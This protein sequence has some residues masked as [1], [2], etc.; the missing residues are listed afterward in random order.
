MTIPPPLTFAALHRRELT[1]DP[2]SWIVAGL[3]PLAAL[4]WR[5][6]APEVGVMS[7]YGVAALLLPPAVVS[8]VGARLARRTTWAFW[9]S[10]ATRPAGAYRG[11]VVGA[12][13]GV[14][15]PQAAGA[16]VSAAILGAPLDAAVGLVVAVAII[17]VT[18]AVVAGVAAAATLDP[19]KAV[20]IGAAIWGIGVIAFEPAL[21]ALAGAFANRPYEP[22][23]ATLVLMHPLELA[24]VALLQTID[25]PVFVGPTGLLVGRWLGGAAAAWAGASAIVIAV[26][27]TVVA[28]GVFARRE[29]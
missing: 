1:R 14:M 26:A 5:T 4:T 29:R 24:R 13:A 22:W 7:V 8:L 6:L 3:L 11:A 21:V 25:L 18:F 10:L 2:W 19:A 15:L 23:L 28:G 17:V 9:G 20:A 12:A 27:A 16:A